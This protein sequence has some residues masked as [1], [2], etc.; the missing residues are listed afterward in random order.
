M[1]VILHQSAITGKSQLHSGIRTDSS[2]TPCFAQRRLNHSAL[3]SHIHLYRLYSYL[4]SFP[5]AFLLH[6]C[7]C[8]V[9]T[10]PFLVCFLFPP[11]RPDTPAQ[12]PLTFP[13]QMSPATPHVLSHSH[14]ITCS[15]AFHYHS[16]VPG[17]GEGQGGERTGR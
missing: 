16:A 12:L 6:Y 7:P 9:V 4:T 13:R 14:K 17:G 2:F 8:G 5:V 3:L 15:Q 1:W 11:R 10:H